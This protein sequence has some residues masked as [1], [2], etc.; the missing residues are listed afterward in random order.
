MMEGHNFRKEIIVKLHEVRNDLFSNP[1][2]DFNQ[3]Y[4]EN[5]GED[6]VS[7]E[8]IDNQLIKHGKISQEKWKVVMDFI[9]ITGQLHQEL[10]NS[11]GDV[12]KKLLKIRTLYEEVEADYNCVDGVVDELKK[13]KDRLVAF[14][15]FPEANEQFQEVGKQLFEV[16]LE[17][18][19]DSLEGKANI[20]Y[21]IAK[22]LEIVLLSL[23]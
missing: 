9:E 19:K 15:K 6:N 1:Y 23:V 2:E 21:I 16:V 11:G 3:K 12:N 14:V 17:A 4:I 8:I 22:L 5:I 18:I 13:A 7:N 10:Q 20:K